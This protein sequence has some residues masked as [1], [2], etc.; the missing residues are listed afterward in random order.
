MLVLECDVSKHNSIFSGQLRR[1]LNHEIEVAVKVFRAVLTLDIVPPVA[2]SELLDR[3]VTVI[4]F[5]LND[6]SKREKGHL[7]ED[8][9][10]WTQER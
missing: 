5:L 10:S 7:I 9:S 2:D 1:H 8:C 4:L 3:D 6:A